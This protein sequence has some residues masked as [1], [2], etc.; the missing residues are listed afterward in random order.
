MFIKFS[1]NSNDASGIIRSLLDWDKIIENCRITREQLMIRARATPETEAVEQGSVK[2][3]NIYIPEFGLYYN[4]EHTALFTLKDW[5]KQ[6]GMYYY[7][8]TEP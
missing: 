5:A 7:L 1:F 6:N 4:L 2:R 8:L 3:P